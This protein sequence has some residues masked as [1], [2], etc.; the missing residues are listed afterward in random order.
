MVAVFHARFHIFLYRFGNKA[1]LAAFIQRVVNYHLFALA[2]VCPKVLAL[3]ALIVADEHICG[4][5]YVLRRA[6]ILLQADN[7]G[8]GVAIES[9]FK[10]KYIFDGS[11]AEFVDALVVI[12]DNAEVIVARREQVYQAELHGICILILVNENVFVEVLIM[13]E[14]IVVLLKKLHNVAEQVVEIHSVRLKKAAVVK[15][16]DLSYLSLAEF[17]FIHLVILIG[18]DHL[19]FLCRDR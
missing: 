15:L 2:E 16:V 1:R 19:V 9:L 12:A 6:V 13:Q 3:S 11:S 17:V 18:R 4:S 5:K 7:I 10:R 8:I 14:H